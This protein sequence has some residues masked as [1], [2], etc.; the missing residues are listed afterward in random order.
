MRRRTDRTK[1]L[2]RAAHFLGVVFALSALAMAGLIDG[3]RINGE[4]C[5]IWLF[6]AV[7]AIGSASYLGSMALSDMVE[8]G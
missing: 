3:E 1:A 8:R 2:T 7:F 4:P 5:S 6:M